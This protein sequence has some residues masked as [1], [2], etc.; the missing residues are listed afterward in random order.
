LMMGDISQVADL[1]LDEVAKNYPEALRPSLMAQI[2]N[3]L[4]KIK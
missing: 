2:E 3:E 4:V 1:S